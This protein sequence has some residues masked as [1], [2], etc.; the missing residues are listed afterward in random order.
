MS[1]ELTKNLLKEKNKLLLFAKIDH[2]ANGYVV[3]AVISPEKDVNDVISKIT[4]QP[5]YGA[6]SRKR[7]LG[8]LGKLWG[9][10]FELVAKLEAVIG[11]LE[12]CVSV[13]DNRC[14]A[15]YKSEDVLNNFEE[16]LGFAHVVSR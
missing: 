9:G 13:G 3:I 1:K 2:T 12:K 7:S 5:F 11:V 6:R 15:I 14:F 10:N 16:R 4:S 8:V